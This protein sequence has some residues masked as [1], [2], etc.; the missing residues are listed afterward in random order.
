MPQLACKS[1]DQTCD[2]QE[3]PE[4]GAQVNYV[5]GNIT[6]ISFMAGYGANPPTFLYHKSSYNSYI[7][8][9]LRHGPHKSAC[10]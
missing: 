2:A 9:P 7:A 4:C 10:P 1:V 8:Y 6:G 3:M 5:L